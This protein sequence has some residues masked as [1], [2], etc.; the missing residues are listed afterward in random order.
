MS[1]N[2]RLRLIAGPNG[3]GKTTL[4]DELR[5]TYNLP[6][7]EYTNPDEIEKTLDI[8]APITRS[9]QAQSISKQQ[10]QKWLEQ[11]ISHCYESVMS[12]HSHLEYMQ[13]ANNKSF[14]S[15]LYYVCIKDP[16]INVSRVNERVL[17][18][19]HPVPIEKIVN[20]YYRSLAQLFDMSQLCRRAYFFD[21]TVNLESFAEIT[22]DA[23]LVLDLPKYYRL[24]P[25]WFR[26]NLLLKWPKEKIK[27]LR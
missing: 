1:I 2:K 4:T 19:G 12:H 26:E 9:K 24:E 7:G 17:S 14:R 8:S 16:Y 3:S 18:G 25:L 23:V 21:N 27:I 11:G 15:Y 10:R 20:R 6:L 5:Q 13:Q 22:P